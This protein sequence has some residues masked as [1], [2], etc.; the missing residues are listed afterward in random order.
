VLLNLLSN[1]VKFTEA[2][3]VTLSALR[4]GDAAWC[5]SVTDTGIGMSADQLDVVFNPFQ[6]A[7][8]S[9]TR[10]F[11]GTGLGLAICKRLLELMRGEIEVQSTPGQAAVF[12]ARL[13]YVPV[14][15]HAAAAQRP[16]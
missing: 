2:G 4:Q 15:A 7:D 5:S 13:P 12:E 6:Q 1:A 3:S 14:A 8:G 16:D 9:T 11:G 10:K